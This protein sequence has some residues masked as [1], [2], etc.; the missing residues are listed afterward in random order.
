MV[1]TRTPVLSPQWQHQI[2]SELEE[3]EKL[4]WAAQPLPRVYRRRAIGAVLF[5]IP[6]TAFAVFW[7]VGASGAWNTHPHRPSTAPFALFPLFG[8]PFVLIGLGMLTSPFWMGRKAR[9][10]LYALTNRRAIIFEGRIFG[11][12]NVQTFMPDRLTSMTR[13]ERADGTGDLIFEQFLQNASRNSTM[14]RCGFLGIERVHD[15]EE[16]IM[17]TLL[18]TRTPSAAS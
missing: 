10:V 2:D 18:K 8:V 3:G 11:G 4:I 9:R 14:V 1:I 12:I 17:E 6:W 13:N 15:V 16:L 5:G 7:M